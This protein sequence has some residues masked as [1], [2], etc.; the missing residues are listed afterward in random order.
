[1]GGRSGCAVMLATVLFGACTFGSGERST[2]VSTPSPSVDPEEEFSDDI[3]DLCVP[4]R[5]AAA[6]VD[7]AKG[8]AQLAQRLDRMVDA[9][10]DLLRE[11]RR[12]KAPPRLQKSFDTYL[13]TLRSAINLRHQ[14]LLEAKN[15]SH[16]VNLDLRLAKTERKLFDIARRLGLSLSCPPSDERGVDL[17]LASAKANQ[18]CFRLYQK[19]KKSEALKQSLVT[20]TTARAALVTLLD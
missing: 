18:A 6:A 10:E 17:F 15:L 19:I 4:Y 14:I 7:T 12:Q 13:S 3:T 11:G 16:A 20:R 9:S 8:R 5:R 2:A 1:M